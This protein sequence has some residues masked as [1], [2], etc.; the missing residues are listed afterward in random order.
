[1]ALADYRKQADYLGEVLRVV[2]AYYTAVST[3]KPRPINLQELDKLMDAVIAVAGNLATLSAAVAVPQ[4]QGA[5]PTADR[6]AAINKWL[7]TASAQQIITFLSAHKLT[8]LDVPTLLVYSLDQLQGMFRK[9][10]GS[11]TNAAAIAALS[12]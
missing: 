6:A 9:L 8:V 4:A 10:V 11:T 7:A 3:Q 12:Q 5:P 1:M 2:A